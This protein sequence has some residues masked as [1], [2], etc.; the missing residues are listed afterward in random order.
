VHNIGQQCTHGVL[1]SHVHILETYFTRE[2]S[3]LAQQH[4]AWL[5]KQKDWNISFVRRDSDFLDSWRRGR[6]IIE[7][8]EQIVGRIELAYDNRALN[9]E[10]M[11]KSKIIEAAL[12]RYKRMIQEARLLET[13]VRD[14]IQLNVGNLS[15]LESRKSI[16][17]ADSVGRISWLAFIFSPISIACSFFGMNIQ[18]LNGSGVSWRVFF[19]SAGALSGLVVVLNPVLWRKLLLGKLFYIIR[20]VINKI[21]I[22]MK[23]T[24][25]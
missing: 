2:I 19:I 10:A 23:R 8:F 6:C 3:H 11:P 1:R 25:T 22:R 20:I 12:S 7:D 24:D 9:S 17:Q 16:K 13:H 18:E 15:L 14:E 4:F 21:T 5:H